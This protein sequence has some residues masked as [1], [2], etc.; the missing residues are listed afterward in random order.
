MLLCRKIA[1]VHAKDK[2]L[3]YCCVHT[4]LDLSGFEGR[5]DGHCHAGLEH[6]RNYP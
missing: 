2:R 6:F 1:D 4:K 5:S 3:G